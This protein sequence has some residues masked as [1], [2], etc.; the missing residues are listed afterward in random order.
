MKS[1][2]KDDRIM[3]DISSWDTETY[4]RGS[5]LKGLYLLRSYCA[6]GKMLLEMIN[7]LLKKRK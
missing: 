2:W 3:V 6:I 4:D 7:G 1:F 5:P